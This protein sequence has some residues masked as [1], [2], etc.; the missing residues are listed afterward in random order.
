MRDPWMRGVLTVSALHLLALGFGLHPWDSVTKAFLAPLV[1]AW[2]WSRRGPVRLID[3]LVLCFLGDVFLELDGTFAVGLVC[4]ALAHV[5]FIWTGA[6][7]GAL[8]SLRRDPIVIAT[9]AVPTVALLGFLWGDLSAGL[10]ILVVAYAAL[11][12]TMAG[13]MSKLNLLAGAG[14]VAFMASD[15]LIGLG[16]ADL[17][18]AGALVPRLAI[19][20]LYIGAILMITIG[21]MRVD[22]S[23]SEPI[24]TPTS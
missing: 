3:S 7:Y 19:M 6:A 5:F 20:V 24:A 23:D 16:Q 12:A 17:L 18:D 22:Q 11:L 1:A 4:F 9:L 10:W 13:T 15:A 14:A 2:V 8:D 21:V